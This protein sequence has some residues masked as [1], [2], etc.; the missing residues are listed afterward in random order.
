MLLIMARRTAPAP[1]FGMELAAQLCFDLYA[2]SRAVTNAYRPLLARLKLTYPQYLVMLVLW[3]RGRAT[4]RELGEELQ[5][6]SGTLSPLL[7]RLMVAGLID[8][9]RRTDDERTVEAVLTD[10]GRALQ[11]EAESIPRAIGTAMGLRPAEFAAL[12]R[13][14]HRLT[15]NVSTTEAV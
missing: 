4:V 5:L 10:S 9:V 13:A 8:R 15:S 2:A 3:E 14:L 12:K 6:D 7:K 1:E 11:A